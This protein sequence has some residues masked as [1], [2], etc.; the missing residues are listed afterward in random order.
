MVQAFHDVIRNKIKQSLEW[1]GSLISMELSADGD[2]VACGSQDTYGALLAS[3]DWRRF[4]DSGY[5]GKPRNSKS[6]IFLTGGYENNRLE[7]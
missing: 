6:S 7:L 1:K 3:V 2:I 5:P 4:H